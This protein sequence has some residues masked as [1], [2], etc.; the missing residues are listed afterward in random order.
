MTSRRPNGDVRRHSR[1]SARVPW[2]TSPPP[3]S[4]HDRTKRRSRRVCISYPTRFAQRYRYGTMHFAEWHPWV[5]PAPDIP[6]VVDSA[7]RM[8][9]GP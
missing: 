4:R 2:L 5:C 9:P 7:L 1:A 3:I 8:T 6:V